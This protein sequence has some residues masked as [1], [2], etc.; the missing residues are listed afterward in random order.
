VSPLVSVSR[1]AATAGSAILVDGVS[2]D[3]WAGEVTALVGASG[4][5]KTTSALALLGSAAMA[6]GSRAR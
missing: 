1:L 3:V 4:S 5:G 6:S 2:F